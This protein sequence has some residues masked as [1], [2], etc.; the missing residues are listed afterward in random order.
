M[1]RKLRTPVGLECFG[2]VAALRINDDNNRHLAARY[3]AWSAEE[4]A[5]RRP[6]VFD[7]R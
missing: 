7:R 2:V 6:F 4:P 3:S 1:G 5:S